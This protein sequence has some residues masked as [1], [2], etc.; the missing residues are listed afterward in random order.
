[1]FSSR[2]I[3]KITDD[4]LLSSYDLSKEISAFHSLGYLQLNIELCSIGDRDGNG[5]PS[6]VVYRIDIKNS[7]NDS[8]LEFPIERHIYPRYLLRGP[9]CKDKSEI[10][11]RIVLNAQIQILLDYQKKGIATLI[12]KIEEDFYRKLLVKE[13]HLIA[14]KAGRAVWR[15][16]GFILFCDDEGLVESLY[17]EWCRENAVGYVPAKEINEYPENFLLSSKLKRLNMYKIL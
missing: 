6:F 5:N 13:I 12:Y 2:L 15:K 7:H 8:I 10:Y 9:Y 14:I 16:F 3:D 1:M 17:E 11:D 4:K